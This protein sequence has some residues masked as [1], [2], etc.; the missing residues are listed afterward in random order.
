MTRWLP[1][2]PPDRYTAADDLS[3]VALTPALL[4]ADYAAVMQNIPALR[5]WSAQ[6]WPTPFFTRQENLV[7]L[8]RHAAE[9]RDGVALT[10]SVLVD[11][12]VSGCIYVHSFENALRTRDVEPPQPPPLPFSDAVA[13]GWA[14]GVEAERLISAT[15][16]LLGSPPFAFTRLW[17]Q[18]NTQCPEQMAACTRLGLT[19]A[20]TFSGDA[21]VWVLRSAP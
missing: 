19:V 6:D 13:R 11:D 17:W 20:H 4:D 9:Q 7:D 16:A 14:H 12:V 2:N 8:E 5:T 1:P 21:A 10:Y 3:F 18:M 15:F